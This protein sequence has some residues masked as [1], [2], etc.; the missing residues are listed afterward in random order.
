MAAEEIRSALSLLFEPGQVV[1]VRAMTGEGIASGYFDD[2][3]ALAAAVG[4]L[5]ASGTAGIYVTLNEV[6]PALLSR[7]ANRIKMR[8]SKK[9][10]TTADADIT[11]RR[12]FPVDIDPVRPSGVSSTDEEHQ[13]ALV[14]AAE[15]AAYL[16]RERGW[17]APVMADS[18]NGAHLLYRIDLPND[19]EN[20]DLVKQCLEAL[21][22]MFS[23]SAATVDT[24]NFNAARI[25]KI[26]G[27][28]SRKGDHTPD[29][30]HRKSQVLSGADQVDVV[31]KEALCQLASLLPCAPLE[32]KGYKKA[33]DLRDWLTRHGLG[34]AH[35]KPYLGGILFVL[36]EC[37]FSG[38]HRDG[39]YAIQFPGG[40]IHAGCHHASCGSGSQR[41]QELVEKYEPRH[42]KARRSSS[43]KPSGSRVGNA[44]PLPPGELPGREEAL[45]TLQHGDPKKA[46]LAAFAV[47]HEGDEVVAECLIMSLASR[48][49]SN[50][51][52]LHVSVT[53]ESGKGKSHA[54][55]T[56]LRQVPAR[57][58][59]EGAMSNKALFYLE[60][61]QPG[62]VIVLDDRALSED[63]AGILKGVTTSFRTPFL[64][65][66]VSRDRRAQVCTIPERCIWWV[67]KVE[68]A[69]DDQ[70]FNRML[71][72]WIDDTEEQDQRVLARI[73]ERDVAAPDT[74]GEDRPDVMACRAM[75]EMIGQQRFRV[76]IPYATRIRFQAAA[77][78][79]NPEMLLDLIK[80]NVVLRFMQREQVRAGGVISLT[81]NMEDF[82]DATGLYGLLNGTAGGQQT[83]L[84]KR[85]SDILTVIQR[86]QW[87]EFTI[88][89]LQKET[90]LAN[91]SLHKIIH[92]Y[93]S[94]GSTYSG[95][96]EKCPAIAY[97]DRTV[98]T[99]EEAGRISMRRRTNAYTF[100]REMYRSW[101]A[102]GE[103]WLDDDPDDP[104]APSA[105]SSDI[106]D[107]SMDAAGYENNGEGSDSPFT[108]NN[109][110]KLLCT[111]VSFRTS[112]YT[113]HPICD[114]DHASACV[115]DS[116]I[117]AGHNSIP[118]HSAP[119]DEPATE[120]SP[121]SFPQ[122]FPQGQKAGNMQQS[123]EGPGTSVS[124]IRAVDYKPLDI[125]EKA[126]CFL[127][128]RAW[129][130]Y[131]E[132]LTKERRLRPDKTARRI[133]KPCYQDAKR[134]A[135]QEAVILPGIIDLTRLEPLKSSVGRCSVC[136]LDR[137]AY[138]D[139]STG[140]SL[141]ESCYRRVAGDQGCGEVIG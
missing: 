111:K 20:R 128:G 10:A 110:N 109:K 50:T 13:A 11:R 54:F 30:P 52:G 23:N 26:Y 32:I 1:E 93:A 45:A 62:S 91:A 124:R 106:R 113:Q 34:I 31:E 43:V 132:K 77:N 68:G 95:L 125:P 47:D 2:Q 122:S 29:R 33:I 36:D 64:Y 35:E 78:R 58:R 86:S 9:D 105:D 61:L 70:V 65:R 112:G 15:I 84:T 108:N 94:R 56:M 141:C 16:G 59:L 39:A 135:Q 104:S 76:V 46:M 103:V 139:R 21:D 8:L 116:E 137:A 80:A 17:P 140:T 63:M 72:C 92:G 123:A 6:N 71:T 57:F 48:S 51:N 3:D 55:A 107:V 24:A 102:G 119:I 98:V 67:A 60:D 28:T 138:I 121:L 133:C 66:T 83:K 115:C 38:A 120:Y 131:V 37:P 127:C 90:G 53:G 88:P 25:W 97:C 4:P 130:H 101:C 117:A 79:R 69:G 85:E 18:G 136:N 82:R 7:R 114:E 41:W 100:D 42:A 129:S 14:R 134:Q 126:P 5:D 96:L 19:E 74:A 22:T 44:S 75:W 49:V 89:M 118:S 81:A 87:P 27:T 12:W 40:A 99:D 73:L